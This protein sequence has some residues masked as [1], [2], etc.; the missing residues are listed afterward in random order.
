MRLWRENDEKEKEMNSVSEITVKVS[1][2]EQ[3]YSQKFLEY[4]PLT[5]SHDDPKLKAFVE[6]TV[7]DFKGQVEDV[8]VKV[9]YRWN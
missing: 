4:T 2:P 6:Q 5:L 8:V 3:R 9:S 7:R 1:N